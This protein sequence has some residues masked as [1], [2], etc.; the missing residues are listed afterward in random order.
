MTT[1]SRYL[2]RDPRWT[3]AKRSST[4]PATVAGGRCNSPIWPGERVFHYP[5]TGTTYCATC[6]PSVAAQADSELADDDTYGTWS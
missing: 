3:V 2:A 1:R 4:C 5:A 6:S